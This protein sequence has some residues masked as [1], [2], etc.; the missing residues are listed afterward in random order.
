MSKAKLGRNPLGNSKNPKYVHSL[1]LLDEKPFL[2]HVLGSRPLEKLKEM[3]IQVDWSEV[4]KS[5]VGDK[6]KR[7]SRFFPNSST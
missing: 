2:D 1:P 6:I 4:Y 7:I 3:D 5:L